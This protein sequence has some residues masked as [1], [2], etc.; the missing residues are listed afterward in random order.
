MLKPKGHLIK[1][2]FLSWI[3]LGFLKILPLSPLAIIVALYSYLADLFPSAFLPRKQRKPVSWG[4]KK[5]KKRYV[6]N[7]LKG[8]QQLQLP[9]LTS[10]THPCCFWAIFILFA[11][12]L[13]QSGRVIGGR[14][15]TICLLHPSGIQAVAASKRWQEKGSFSACYFSEGDPLLHRGQ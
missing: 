2:H 14:P 9:G 13:G 11:F 8:T 10:P 15:T 6:E 3:L 4:S 5:K 12:E 7:K 1:R